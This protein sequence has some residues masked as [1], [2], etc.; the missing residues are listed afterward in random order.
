MIKIFTKYLIAFQVFICILFTYN[1]ADAQL[2]LTLS[3]VDPS[4]NS[5]DDGSA[6]V[7]AS[8]GTPPYSYNWNTGQFTDSISNLIAGNYLVTV[9]DFN[10][11]TANG[12][13]ELENP[14]ILQTHLELSDTLLTCNFRLIIATS[15]PYGGT[16]PYTYEWVFPNTNI[17]TTQSVNI[18]QPGIYTHRVHDAHGCTYEEQFQIFS[19][20]FPVLQT[21]LLD[22]ITCNGQHNGNA[23]V[24]IS[25]GLP[26]YDILWSNGDTDTLL[27]DVGV[28]SYLVTVTDAS[29]CSNLAAVYVPEPLPLTIELTKTDITCNGDFTGTVY[30]SVIGGT[31]PYSYFWNNGGMTQGMTNLPAGE[32]SVT[33]T[34]KRGCYIIDSIEILQAPR[35]NTILIKRNVTCHGGNDGRASVIATNGIP[36]YTY[37]WS[38]GLHSTQINNLIAGKYYVTVVDSNLCAVVDSAIITEPDAVITTVVTSPENFG[39]MDGTAT[40]LVENGEEPFTY[41]WSTGDSTAHITGLSSGFYYVTVTDDNGCTSTAEGYVEADNCAMEIH[42]V[43]VPVACYGESNGGVFPV[44]DTP[45]VEPYYY[46]WSNGSTEANLMNVPAGS[47]TVTVTDNTNCS[48]VASIILTQPDPFQI[49]YSI[50]QP[51]GPDN[52][53]GTVTFII[54]GG[55]Q[56]YSID[57]KGTTYTDNNK[58]TIPGFPPGIYTL[59]VE[60]NKGCTQEVSF[61]VNSYDCQLT[62]SITPDFLNNCPGQSSARLCASF[63][64]N[65][66]DVTYSWSNQTFEQCADNLKAGT[67]EV[68]VTDT[69]GCTAHAQF[70]LVDPTTMDYTNLVVNAGTGVNGSISLIVIGGTPPYSYNWTKDGIQFATTRDIF[71]LPKGTYVLQVTDSKGCKVTFEPIVIKPLANNV[72]LNNDLI[73][74]YPNPVKEQLLV[75]IAGDQTITN[76]KFEFLDVSGNTMTSNYAALGKGEYMLNT[77]SLSAGV[78]LLKISTNN[79][80]FLGKIIRIK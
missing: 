25:S 17:D 75:K 69:V 43:M 49:T 32:Y 14:V 40:A 45:G 11:L 26:P 62:A 58:I 29:G 51:T 41:A 46:N 78:Y 65:L 63:T 64:N 50:E 80:V 37:S 18:N 79:A 71:G 12:S 28:G 6:W 48:E 76:L 2:S 19:E 9:T 3:K 13:I 77:S 44:F 39:M 8:G 33:V 55:N 27:N 60:D 15:N 16:P 74:L 20:G 52:P 67:Y 54:S 5:S 7:D 53:T 73:T 1:S 38:N 35:I 4:C 36:P 66:G 10:G 70:Q 56:P 23:V 47:Y 21:E 59:Q 30:A 42:L 22:S 68:V 34:D 31:E 57:Y 72:L 24:H 61:T